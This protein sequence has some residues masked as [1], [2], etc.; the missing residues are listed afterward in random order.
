M[1]GLTPV[2]L[3]TRSASTRLPLDSCTAHRRAV[4]LRWPRRGCRCSTV[5][6]LVSHQSLIMPPAVG[7]IM[8]GTMRSPISTTRELHAARG[9][10]LH[11]DAAD[12]AG[13]HLQHARALGGAAARW[14]AH[15]PASSR[16]ARRA[17]R[18][19][20]SAGCIGL[21]P[22]AMSRRVEGQRRCR[23]R[24][25]TRA[26]AP[27]RRCRGA[28]APQRRCAAVWKWLGVVAQVRARLADVADQQVGDRHARVRRLGLVADDDDLVVAARACGWSR[29][30]S[31]RPGR[32]RGSRVSSCRFLLKRNKAVRRTALR[33]MPGAAPASYR[34]RRVRVSGLSVPSASQPRTS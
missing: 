30:R 25:C 4:A 11:D 16:G 26:L 12:E 3:M 6:P 20:G 13:A 14:R 33:V 2:A 31:R 15:R 1:F 8:R 32:R 34:P 17:G 22:V 9:Q 7:P 27:R 10:R 18:C 24:A 23:R 29:R 28:A 5:T 21:E 19:R